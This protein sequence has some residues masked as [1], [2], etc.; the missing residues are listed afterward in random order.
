MKVCH[1]PSALT[2][3]ITRN[4]GISLRFIASLHS[5]L[6]GLPVRFTRVVKDNRNNIFVIPAQAGIQSRACRHQKFPR[7]K[8]AARTLICQFWHMGHRARM[9][10]WTMTALAFYAA[11]SDERV[12]LADQARVRQGLV[13]M[14]EC[15]LL[16]RPNGTNPLYACLQVLS[17]TI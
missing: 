16:S 2:T 7:R 14:S 4:A 11:C 13:S 3:S 12:P 6:L 8:A 15:A 1:Y 9:R 10:C 5:G 17:D